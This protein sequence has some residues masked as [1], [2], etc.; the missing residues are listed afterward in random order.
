MCEIRYIARV[1]EYVRTHVS[2]CG[3]ECNV[4]C[5]PP[6]VP[7]PLNDHS[8]ENNIFDERLRPAAYTNTHTRILD[9]DQ[10][11]PGLGATLPEKQLFICIQN[12]GK[13][14]KRNI[15]KQKLSAIGRCRGY[16]CT[17]H[18]R[19]ASDAYFVFIKSHNKAAIK[20]EKINSRQSLRIRA[21]DR[22]MWYQTGFKLKTISFTIK[23]WNDGHKSGG[24]RMSIDCVPWRLWILLLYFMVLW[25]HLDIESPDNVSQCLDNVWE[26]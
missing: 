6:H 23:C 8:I 7:H 22:W 4:A 20:I 19:I 24:N 14:Q 11:N 2:V 15:L 17:D 10:R 26:S 18:Q 12:D 25:S 21:V 16:R 1:I 5:K 9:S 13:V 3:I